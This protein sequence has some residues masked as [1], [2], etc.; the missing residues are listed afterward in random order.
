MRWNC[1]E[2]VR[3]RS[4]KRSA[5][6]NLHDLVWLVACGESSTETH[7]VFCSKF[8]LNVLSLRHMDA[9]TEQDKA[10]GLYKWAKLFKAETW[11]ELKDLTENSEVYEDMMVTMAEL[12]NDDKIRMQMEA[13]ERYL[14]DWNTQQSL[15]ADTQKKLDEAESR[16]D[17]ERNRADEEKNRADKEK[18]RADEL[19]KNVEMSV[20]KLYQEGMT[21]EKIADILGCSIDKIKEWVKTD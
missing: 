8:R 5:E 10:D 2:K 13:R 1:R 21:L 7:R 12:T 6:Q 3:A 16:A 20:V 15:L 4:R 14:R 11:E 18:S 9:A 19:E 17:K